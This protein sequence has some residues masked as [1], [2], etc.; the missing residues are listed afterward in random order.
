MTTHQLT[1]VAAGDTPDPV[2][3]TDTPPVRTLCLVD[4][5]N[6]ACSSEV[7][8]SKVNHIQRLVNRTV[9]LRDDDHVVIASSHHNAVATCY[10]WQGSAQR[11][12]RS[13]HDGAD[14]ALLD[15]IA[16]PEWVAARYQRVVIASGDHI[17]SWA[18]ARLKAAGLDVVVIAPPVGL[19]KRLR[20]A[21]GPA[22]RPLGFG[23][24]SEIHTLYTRSKDSQ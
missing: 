16:D 1:L 6:M 18:V 20:L 15:V 9:D 3:T 11:R 24:A 10:G 2:P 14:I 4:I 5:E 8:A 17:F 23:F 7:A 22:V 21:A 12:I 19:S 13:G